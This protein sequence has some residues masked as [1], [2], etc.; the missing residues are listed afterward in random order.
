MSAPSTPPGYHSITPY[1][2]VGDVDGSIAFVRAAFEAEVTERL[3]DDAGQARHAEVRIGDSKLMLGNGPA[4]SAVLYHYVADVDAVF[5]RAV[6]AGGTVFQ[7]PRD[8][9]Y[10]DR[11]AAVNDPFGVQWWI[12]TRKE[13]L[14]SEQMQAR[15]GEARPD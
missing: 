3:T 4:G 7:E 12:A 11:V 14:T 2:L 15:M 10:G 9:F 5:A 6:E 1:L 13:T 8:E